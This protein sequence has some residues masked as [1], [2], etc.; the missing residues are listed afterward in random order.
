MVI[1]GL[2]LLHLHF[3]LLITLNESPDPSERKFADA[4]LALRNPRQEAW[5]KNDGSILQSASRNKL[6]NFCVCCLPAVSRYNLQTHS[7]NCLN[8]ANTA[9]SICNLVI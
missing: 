1:L 2:F 4:D 6:L 7:V 3:L 8:L 9:C 5:G